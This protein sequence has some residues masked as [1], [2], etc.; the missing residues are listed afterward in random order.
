MGAA[1]HCRRGAVG[2]GID[3]DVGVAARQRPRAHAGVPVDAHGR[4][5]ID[6]VFAAGDV[7]A[8]FDPCYGRHV[9]GSHWEAAGRQGA[10]AARLM[11][12]LDPG[13]APLT[14]FWTDQYGLRIQYLGRSR[15]A[16]SFEID[17]E[18]EQRSFTATFTQAGRAVAALLVDR[19]RSLPAARKAIDKEPTM[20]YLRTD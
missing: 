18:P 3:P 8:T 20:S 1:V 16:D 4:T 11:L 2:V 7:A 14:S 19:P 15:L 12:G 17:G 9:P 13:A 5:A 6:G 10:R